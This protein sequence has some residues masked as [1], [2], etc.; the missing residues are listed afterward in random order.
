MNNHL[1][2]STYLNSSRTDFIKGSHSI[3]DEFYN[4]I[5]IIIPYTPGSISQEY[6]IC[7]G[8]FAYWEKKK[9]NRETPILVKYFIQMK[10]QNQEM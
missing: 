10:L 4:F 3:E 5:K 9:K 8:P 6:N 7:L 2:N 1:W